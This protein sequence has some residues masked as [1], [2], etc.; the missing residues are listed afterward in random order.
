[1]G[2]AP[3]PGLLMMTWGFAAASA[4]P[5]KLITKSKTRLDSRLLG[6]FFVMRVIVRLS[7]SPLSLR[8]DKGSSG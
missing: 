2:R 1:M 8:Q 7:L 4:E 6:N 3:W 5:A